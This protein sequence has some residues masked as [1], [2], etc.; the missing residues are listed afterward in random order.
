[1][2]QELGKSVGL[3]ERWSAKFDWLARVQAHVGHLAIV[4]RE[5][6]E[7]LRVGKAAEWEQ[8]EQQL[9]ETEWTLRGE[10]VEAG[11]ESPRQVQR[12]QPGATLGD[13]ARA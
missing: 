5:A 2:G 10:L 4:E 7:A 11:L 3:I 8:R 12:Q 13:V 9:R 6:A 1:V